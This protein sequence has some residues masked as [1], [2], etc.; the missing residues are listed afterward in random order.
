MTAG[1]HSSRQQNKYPNKYQN[2]YRNNNCGSGDPPGAPA[3]GKK[4]VRSSDFIS[5]TQINLR[6]TKGA[7]G[8]LLSNIF[9]KRNPVVLATEPYVETNNQ[10]PKVHKD[11]VP[12]YYKKGDVRPRAAILIHKSLAD[13]CWELPQFTT[14]DQIA[15]KINHDSKDI[16][17]VSSY[18]DSTLD[19]VPPTEMTPLVDYAKQH[20]LPIVIS[21]DTNSQHCLWG[22]KKNNQRGENLLD[23]LD[24]HELT[25]S[26]RGSS[27]TFFN[28][29]GH[30]SIIDL[31][32]TNRAAED[33]IQDWHVSSKFSNS[34]HC[35]IF[36]EINSSTKHEP[37][38]VRIARN[39]NWESFRENLILD[40][41]LG[42]LNQKELRNDSDLDQ[43]AIGLNQILIESFKSSKL[44]VQ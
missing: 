32:I 40:Q 25:W 14:K 42:S 12:F 35:Y 8:T 41:R 9:A 43:A 23:Y 22:N 44:P 15:I 2:K 20:N 28:T 36:Y 30:S 4:F 10:L 34:D 7:W 38:Q 31:T 39:T 16:I 21:S 5:I 26:N 24:S 37:K 3:K 13:K 27:S 29:R 1:T 18:M 33:L 11:L 6:H 19:N 17:L